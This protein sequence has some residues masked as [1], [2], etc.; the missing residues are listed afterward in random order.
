MST[1]DQT[2]Q[3]SL[4][5]ANVWLTY[6]KGG[7]TQAIDTTTTGTTLQRDYLVTSIFALDEITLT[8]PQD[9]NR[10]GGGT[11]TIEAGTAYPKTQILLPNGTVISQGRARFTS[12]L[13]DSS[14]HTWE[15]VSD[16]AVTTHPGGSR[17]VSVAFGAFKLQYVVQAD[18]AAG[19]EGR[20]TDLLMPSSEDLTD[21]DIQDRSMNIL[22]TDASKPAVATFTVRPRSAPRSVNHIGSVPPVFNLVNER[23]NAGM[24]TSYLPSVAAPIKLN[25][26]GFEY[27]FGHPTMINGVYKM[28]LP[29]T[30]NVDISGDE[31]AVFT[32]DESIKN[33]VLVDNPVIITPDNHDIVGVLVV[34]GLPPHDT[35]TTT[36]DHRIQSAI[37][38]GTT[39]TN[40]SLGG[41]PVPVNGI[42]ELYT[43]VPAGTELMATGPTLVVYENLAET[44]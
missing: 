1:E 34:G 2:I 5:T 9:S 8:L 32:V 39:G 11:I 10:R 28:R 37:S 29:L 31:Y 25:I 41:A 23:I 14:K 27:R 13:T 4:G 26:D 19:V 6:A 44:R 42:E 12:E 21:T 15:W 24:L 7:A 20:I 36:V 30:A 38:L 3:Q 22:S 18:A 40:L 17:L 33:L 16:T 43:F 35:F